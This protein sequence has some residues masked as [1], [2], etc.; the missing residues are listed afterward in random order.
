MSNINLSKPNL[1][2]NVLNEGYNLSQISV[3]YL[4]ELNTMI[5]VYPL[6]GEMLMQVDVNECRGF[7]GE[8][9]PQTLDTNEWKQFFLAN[10]QDVEFMHE[11][12][13]QSLVRKEL[14]IINELKMKEHRM[15]KQYL[16]QVMNGERG[17]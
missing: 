1:R 2:A 4:K 15:S 16:E 7:Y 12:L 17:W 9:A 3:A 13:I 10:E 14:I 6:L 5:V 8:H 11:R